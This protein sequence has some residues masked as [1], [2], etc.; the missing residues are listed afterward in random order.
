MRLGSFRMEAR[1]EVH[2]LR[3]WAEGLVRRVFVFEDDELVSF[4]DA[5]TADRWN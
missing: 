5:G 1:D 3:D 4:G 2:H